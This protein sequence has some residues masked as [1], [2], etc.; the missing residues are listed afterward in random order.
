MKVPFLTLLTLALASLAC[1][2]QVSSRVTNA[3][4]ALPTPTPTALLTPTTTPTQ[5]LGDSSWTA[6]VE[7]PTVRV[8][9]LPNGEPTGDYLAAGDQVEI[10]RCTV[11]WCQIS[12][13]FRGWVFRGCL[14]DNPKK[15][16]CEAE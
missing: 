6:S 10:L 8:R 13:P 2:L 11:R 1:S 7:L 5:E 4:A 3:E 12:K 15:L 14:S 9:A 16:G